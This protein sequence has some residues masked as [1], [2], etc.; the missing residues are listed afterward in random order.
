MCVICCH[1]NNM[2]DRLTPPPPP[3][4]SALLKGNKETTVSEQRP[5]TERGSEGGGRRSEGLLVCLLVCPPPPRDDGKYSSLS[6]YLRSRTMLAG[7]S[8]YSL[9][10]LE[11]RHMEAPSMIRWSA[12]QLTFMMW[13]LTTWPPAS[14]RGRIWQANKNRTDEVRMDRG[15]HL[16]KFF[17]FFKSN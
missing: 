8:R 16:C 13:A 14:N 17:C 10:R 9:H 3:P 5:R 2:I 7:F 1:G 12:D 6:V 11:K 4:P 15:V